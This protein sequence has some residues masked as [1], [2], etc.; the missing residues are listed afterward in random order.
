MFVKQVDMNEAFRL[1]IAGQEVKVLVPTGPG[2]GW[3]CMEPDTL[4]NMLGDVMF[5]RQEPAAVNPDFEAAVQAMENT[6]ATPPPN[7]DGAA[8]GT[9]GDTAEPP[10]KRVGTGGKRKPVDTGKILALHNAGW[11]N[12]A[13]AEEMKMSEK[14]VWYYI[15]K[16]RKGK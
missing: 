10:S 14:M 3:A 6:Q 15:D 13:I 7:A 5:F 11:T 8:A 12:K 4:Q 16:A 1:A 2:N 9:A